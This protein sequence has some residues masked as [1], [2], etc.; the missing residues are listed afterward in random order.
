M[1]TN[2]FIHSEVQ[3]IEPNIRIFYDSFDV[4]HSLFRK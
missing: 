2:I 4:I 1:S 3:F